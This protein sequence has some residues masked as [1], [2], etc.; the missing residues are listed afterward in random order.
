MNLFVLH[1]SRFFLTLLCS[2]YLLAISMVFILPA[3]AWLRSAVA[4][5]LFCALVYYLRRDVWMLSSSSNVA[6]RLDSDQI[7]LIARDGREL[8][9]LILPDSVV[10]PALTVLNILPQGKNR[11]RS[12][13]V[14]PDSLDQERFREMRVLLRW[15]D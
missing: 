6:L 2:A 8:P 7:V 1:P 5:L 13:V 14:F 3:A 4:F 11:Q 12:I 10:T 15:R 9:G